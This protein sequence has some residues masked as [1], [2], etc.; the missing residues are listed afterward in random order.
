MSV[1]QTYSRLVDAAV[2]H[3]RKD[4]NTFRREDYPDS[5]SIQMYGQYTLLIGDLTGRAT[6]G[7]RSRNW[8]PE[9]SRG[10]PGHRSAMTAITR[11]CST[12]GR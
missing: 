12:G 2:E 11:I 9:R 10:S 7:P 8:C 1:T 5:E 6:A 3:F 4:R